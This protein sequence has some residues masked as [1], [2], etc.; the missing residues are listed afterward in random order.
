MNRIAYVFSCE[1]SSWKSCQSITK[2]LFSAYQ[3][4]FLKTEQR[5]FDYRF[6]DGKIDFLRL[7]IEIAKYKPTHLIFLDHKPHPVHLI[8]FLYEFLPHKDFQSIEFTFHVFGDFTLYPNEWIK[9]DDYLDQVKVKFVCASDRQVEL[10]KKFIA[11]SSGVV[12]KCPFPVDPKEFSF[13]EEL[14]K[15][16]RQKLNLSEKDVV[17][18]YTGRLSLQKNILPLIQDFHNLLK[19]TSL[20]NVYFVIAGPFDD[21][22]NPYTGIWYRENEFYQKYLSLLD[23]LPESSKERILYLGNLGAENLNLAYCGADMFVSMSAHNDEDFGMSPAEAMM[24]GLP[25]ILSNW[26]GYSSFYELNEEFNKLIQV[27]HDKRFI[28]Y[29]RQE[30]LKALILSINNIDKMRSERSRLAKASLGYLSINSNAVIVKKIFDSPAKKFDGFTDLMK[31]LRMSY[32]SSPPFV[33]PV[34]KV[35]PN[36]SST[37]Y[38]IYES[39]LPEKLQPVS[40]EI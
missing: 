11:K 26:A 9:L 31:K 13:K 37:Y 36:Y 3:K 19:L 10:V 30:L 28:A 4:S 23:G 24:S 14:R 40:K 1:S 35:V 34:Q 25:V 16:F 32:S 29:N 33:E 2:N 38:E 12:F 21:L 39:Y 15:K 27:K 20:K 8:V 7:A 22:G 6:D 5:T 17:L 18:L